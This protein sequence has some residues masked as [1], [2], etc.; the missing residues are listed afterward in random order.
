MGVASIFSRG[1]G[2]VGALFFPQKLMTILVIV[3]NIQVNLLK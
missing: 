1:G 3:L 2:E